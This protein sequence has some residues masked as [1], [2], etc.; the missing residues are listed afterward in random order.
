[1]KRLII[2]ML[3]IIAAAACAKLSVVPKLASPVP[4]PP[5][6][7]WTGASGGFT[8]RWTAGDITAFKTGTS[9]Q[10]LSQEGLTILDFHQKVRMQTA[11]CD[12]VRVSQLQSV[13]GPIVSILDTDTMKCVNGFTGADRKTVA[14]D[15]ARPRVPLLLTDYVPAHE[16]NSLLTR[17]A[18]ECS[19][20]PTNLLNRFAFEQLSGNVVVVSFSLPHTCTTAKLSVALNVPTKLREPL[21]LAARGQQGF[22]LRDQPRI[23][24]GQ[25]TTIN[26]HYLIT[27]P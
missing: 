11:D 16:L 21:A 15:L 26:Y 9:Q 2:V 17:V 14:I 27:S 10:A 3:V 25:T 23:A 13:V 12:L 8:I 20:K 18:H 19:S 7:I 24:G 6:V 1:M 5:K 4:G 22:L